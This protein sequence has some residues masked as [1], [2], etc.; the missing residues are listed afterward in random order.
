M[1]YTPES[2][3][4]Y[5]N[6]IEARSQLEKIINLANEKKGLLD[7]LLRTCDINNSLL[8]PESCPPGEVSYTNLFV[9]LEFALISN[10]FYSRR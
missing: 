6:L 7:N 9:K 3:S 8:W 2:H 4:D 5:H 1:Q 10:I